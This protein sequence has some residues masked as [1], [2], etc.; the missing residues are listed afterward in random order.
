ML[1]LPDHLIFPW[2]Q[3]VIILSP[4]PPA[5]SKPLFSPFRPTSHLV[6]VGLYDKCC[7]IPSGGSRPT[8]PIPKTG[9]A[10]IKRVFVT[11]VHS[12]PFTCTNTP[13]WIPEFV[14][15]S[16]ITYFSLDAILSSL[17]VKSI[18]RDSYPCCY[19]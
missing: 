8:V 12:L 15:N 3:K 5:A 11:L 7:C 18:K 9:V 10:N 2:Q 1:K 13:S 17:V 14:H 4:F 6:S 16:V 19:T